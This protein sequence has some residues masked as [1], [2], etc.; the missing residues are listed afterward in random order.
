MQAPLQLTIRHMAHSDALTTRVSEHAARLDR[1]CPDIMS[2]RVLIEQLIRHKSLGQAFNVRLAVRV[3]GQE[4]VETR[5]SHTDV[6]IALRDAF[7]AVARRLEEADRRERTRMVK[8][9]A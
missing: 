1:F 6:H 2:C 9:P 7:A 3:P 8:H 5:D 4:L